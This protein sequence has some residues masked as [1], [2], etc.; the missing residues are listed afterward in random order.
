MLFTMTRKVLTFLTTIV[1]AV[2]SVGV[3]AQ[4]VD[5]TSPYWSGEKRTSPR[6]SG[7]VLQSTVVSPN[8]KIAM[9]NGRTYRV[10]SR[11]GKAVVTDI[12]PYRV[13]LR[14][15]NKVIQLRLLPGR[16]KRSR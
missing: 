10:G 3:Q 16:V 15:S 7:L 6:R 5:P 2:V 11:I 9:I 8:R 12:Q 13:T 14:K 4:L 1:L